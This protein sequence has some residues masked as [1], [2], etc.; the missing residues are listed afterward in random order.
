[1][2]LY[3][4]V[5]ADAI[6]Y[7][8]LK[9]GGAEHW[10]IFTFSY[11]SILLSFNIL[12]GISAVLFFTGFNIASEIMRIIIFTNSELLSNAIWALVVLFIP[13]VTFTYFLVF[14][15]KKYEFILSNYKYRRGKLLLFYFSISV[16]GMFTFSLLS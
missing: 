8:K 10:K 16:I 14:Y 4:A 5:W 15:K 3:Y 7:E 13:S 1:M 12:A 2:N 9:N 11:M 6:N